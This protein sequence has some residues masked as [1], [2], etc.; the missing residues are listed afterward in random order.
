LTTTEISRVVNDVGQ[1]VRAG[2]TVAALI[3]AGLLDAAA[4]EQAKR[5]TIGRAMMG[6]AAW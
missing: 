6:G 2:W 4:W 5:S 1:H 3:A